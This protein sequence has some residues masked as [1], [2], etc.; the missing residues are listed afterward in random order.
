MRC[1]STHLANSVVHCAPN[2]HECN[3]RANY[4]RIH[5]LPRRRTSRNIVHFF[6]SWFILRWIWTEEEWEAEDDVKGGPLDPRKVKNSRE[7]ESTCGTWRCMS[8]PLKRKHGREQDA[9]QWIATNKSSAEAP[10]YRSRLVCTEV[11]HEGV[12]P[13]FSATPPLLSF[14]C[15]EDVFRVEDLFLIT[16]ADVSRAHFF[17]DAVR[18]VYVRLPD[19]DPKAMQCSQACVENCGRRCTSL[20][21]LPTVG[22]NAMVR[23]WRRPKCEPDVKGCFS[24]NFFACSVC[25]EK[26]VYQR[27][28]K[29]APQYDISSEGEDPPRDNSDDEE[30]EP[31]E[32]DSNAAANGNMSID[33][34]PVATDAERGRYREIS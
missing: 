2:D 18:D 20:C 34:R 5:V 1:T 16:T 9:D 6:R 11:R 4:R 25:H 3:V 7:K 21:M 32:V 31:D 14:A 19:E 15:Q 8:T 27:Q 12:E 28:S 33:S 17:A 10:R 22:E 24:V 23:F 29:Q 13:T 30:W 26:G